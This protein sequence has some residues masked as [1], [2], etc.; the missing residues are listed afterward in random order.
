MNISKEEVLGI[1]TTQ[2]NG[3]IEEYNFKKKFPEHYQEVLNCNFPSD[4]KFNQKLYH[5][6]HD[7]LDLKLGLCPVCGERCR[8]NGFNKGYN[9]HCSYSCVQLDKDVRD[10]IENTCLEKYG[11]TSY[12]KTSECQER[13]FNTKLEKYGDGYYSNRDKFKQTCLTKYGKEN[14]LQTEE[15]KE[16]I[17]NTNLD[18]FGVPYYSQTEE[19]KKIVSNYQLNRWENMTED[20]LKTMINHSFQTCNIKYGTNTYTQTI[21]F[22]EKQHQTKEKNKS[23]NTSKIENDFKKYLDE[24][25]IKY[26]YQYS[27]EKYP[28]MCDFY[29][30][31]YEL[32]LEIQGHWT[33]G[34]Y[35]F[36]K[37]DECLNILKIWT[38]KSKT[39]PSYNDAIYI[40]TVKDVL[41]RNTANKNEL[42]Y[43]EVFSNKLNILIKEFERKIKELVKN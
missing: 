42:N 35:P 20:K 43:L 16:R 34:K 21:E 18:K 33:H 13:M 27:S 2:P 22:L 38:E 12:T 36:I 11:E 32:Y 19:F 25:N 9:Q 8:F 6:F 31:D 30:P 14:Y 40:W 37:T 39:R 23:F 3:N 24:N 28:F 10:K 29:F 41:K 26:L 17:I 5:Y 1:I 4:F 7:D 15:C